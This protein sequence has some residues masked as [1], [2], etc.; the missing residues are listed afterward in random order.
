MVVWL[1]LS[2]IEDLNNNK[3]MG[4]EHK[5]RE[6]VD[7]PQIHLIPD[8]KRIF[9]MIKYMGN[10]RE[11]HTGLDRCISMLILYAVLALN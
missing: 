7:V 6:L 10:T 3:F 5:G 9:A 2:I 1:K 4:E 8:F 11:I